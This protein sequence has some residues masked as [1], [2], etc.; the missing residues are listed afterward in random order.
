[1]NTPLD[2]K[3][4]QIFA[5]VFSVPLE[6]VQPDSSPETIETWD[7]L[8]HLNMVLALEQEFGVQFEPEEIEKLLSPALVTALVADKVRALEASQCL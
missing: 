7:S 1:L 3:I 6:S 5:D 8:Q 2:Q 4:R